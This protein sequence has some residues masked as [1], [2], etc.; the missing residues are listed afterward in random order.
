MATQLTQEQVE[1]TTRTRL[2]SS[3]GTS[4]TTTRTWTDGTSIQSYHEYELNQSESLTFLYNL[5]YD[6]D[7]QLSKA[8]ILGVLNSLKYREDNLPFAIEDLNK[9]DSQGVM[10]SPELRRKF[11]MDRIRMG[12]NN[13]F[14]NIPNSREKAL[15]VS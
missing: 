6:D 8:D 2:L 11:Y 14:H 5:L 1:I 9:T 13:W 10:W 15:N 12:A 7:S 4:G 3:N